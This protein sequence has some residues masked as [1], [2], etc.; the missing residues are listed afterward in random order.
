MGLPFGPWQRRQFASRSVFAA[1]LRYV[2]KQRFDNDQANT[3]A[4]RQPDYAVADL[5]LEHRIERLS[6]ALEVRN[7]FDKKYFS[8]GAWNFA[9]SF[10]AFPAA[11]RAVYVSAAYRLE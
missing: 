2:G 7:L 6:L 11:G 3:F 8:Y 10:S 1:D 4:R 5:K 9:S